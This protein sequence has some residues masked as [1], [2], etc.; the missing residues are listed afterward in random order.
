MLELENGKVR[1]IHDL[2]STLGQRTAGRQG[3]CQYL[4]IMIVFWSAT[5]QVPLINRKIKKDQIENV[6]SGQNLMKFSRL[7][8]QKSQMENCKESAAAIDRDF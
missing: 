2:M 7:K 3:A 5:I 1:S 8:N 4:H 6:L